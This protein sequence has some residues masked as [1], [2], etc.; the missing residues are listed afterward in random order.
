M[1]PEIL[2]AVQEVYALVGRGKEKQHRIEDVRV[3]EFIAHY[4]LGNNEL[5]SYMIRN[6]QRFFKEHQPENDFIDN[7]WKQLKIF[8][9]SA[10]KPKVARQK[11]KAALD[12]LSC[13]EANAVLKKELIIWLEAK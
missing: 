8:V 10:D 13:P 11:L 5:L 6:N 12:S 3:Y 4:E 2:D 9:Q 1:Y 7:M